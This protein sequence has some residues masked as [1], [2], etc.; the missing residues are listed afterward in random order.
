MVTG[1]KLHIRPV[2]SSSGELGEPLSAE[3]MRHFVSARPPGGVDRPQ[4]RARSPV[5]QA[6]SRA[7]QAIR[8]VAYRRQGSGLTRNSLGTAPLG[9][10]GRQDPSG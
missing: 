4:Q 3:Q 6:W 10:N 9:S 2:I 8:R 7:W 5:S 1:M